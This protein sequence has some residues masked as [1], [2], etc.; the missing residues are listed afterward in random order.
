MEYDI[1]CTSSTID[2]NDYVNSH[3]QSLKVVSIC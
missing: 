1:L 2:H 3:L